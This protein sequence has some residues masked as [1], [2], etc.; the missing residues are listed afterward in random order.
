[1][2]NNLPLLASGRNSRDVVSENLNLHALEIDFRVDPRWRLFVEAHPN[3]SIYHHPLWLDVL[4]KEYGHRIIAL[5]C[6][7][8]F[9]E[10]RAILPLVYTKG[11]PLHIGGQSGARRLSSLPRTPIAGPLSLG[12]Q[13]TATVLGAAIELAKQDARLRLQIKT[14]TPA[15]E[16]LAEGLICK[17]WRLSYVLELPSHPDDLRLGTS[18]NRARIRWAVKKAAKEGVHIRAAQSKHDL[19][20]WYGLYLETMR[21]NVVPPRSYRFFETLWN[22]MHARGLMELLLAEQS[23]ERGKKLLGGSIFLMFGQTVSYNFN[24]ARKEDFSLRPNDAILL[25][26]IQKACQAG[27]RWFDFGEVPDGHARLAEFKS[28]WG[29]EPRQLL[30]YYYPA[31]SESLNEHP[32]GYIYHVAEAIWQRLPLQTTAMLGDWIYGHL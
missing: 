29:S 1:M 16:T 4:E 28:K 15:L 18:R 9:G 30:R 32:N 14:H 31:S 3:G 10:L 8:G 22:S 27:F 25:F 24:G 17:P 23:G 6:E 21:R 12:R 5:A 20:A 7:D 2:L 19:R 13:A 26:A 11:F